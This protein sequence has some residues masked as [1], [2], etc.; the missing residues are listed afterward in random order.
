MKNPVGQL[1]ITGLLA[2]VALAACSSD[3]LES[4]WEET[5]PLWLAHFQQSYVVHRASLEDAEC[6][7]ILGDRYA[8]DCARGQ[9]IALEWYDRVAGEHLAAWSW[10]PR[11]QPPEEARWFH[12]GAGDYFRLSRVAH[13]RQAELLAQAIANPS[14]AAS[15][16]WLWEAEQMLDQHQQADDL[17]SWLMEEGWEIGAG[18]VAR[19]ISELV[20]AFP[21]PR[22]FLPPSGVTQP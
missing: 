15:P 12:T 20:Q 18:R 17:F 11:L 5:T 14:Y 16:S 4:Y 21:T 13:R 2:L 6:T 8:F 22:P 9:L 1:A 7:E 3:A 10:E 19:E